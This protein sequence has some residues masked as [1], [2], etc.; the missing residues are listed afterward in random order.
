LS[1][2]GQKRDMHVIVARWPRPM[3][4]TTLRVRVCAAEGK[5]RGRM[6]EPCLER[7]AIDPVPATRVMAIS[8]LLA[9][10]AV[11][12]ILVAIRT[13]RKHHVDVLDVRITRTPADRFVAV[14]ARHVAMQAGQ[15]IPG[16]GMIKPCEVIPGGV[17]MTAVARL[18]GELPGMG[19]VGLMTT[20]AG[21]SYAQKRGLR[22]T[23]FADIRDH[24]RRDYQLGSVAIPTVKVGV[25]PVECETGA[26]VGKRGGIDSG[27]IEI[28]TKVILMAVDAMVVGERRVKAFLLPHTSAQRRVALE[29]LVIRGAAA[30]DGVATRAIS[31][32]AQLGVGCS[33]FPWGNELRGREGRGIQHEAP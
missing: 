30:P 29:T 31:H 24:V 14:F 6:V 32:A 13:T 21:G 19:I 3:A 11:V 33:Q 20:E 22:P 4:T 18:V 26:V 28:E 1:R 9:H 15:A 10:L 5:G 25:T 16:L 17:A 8:A 2:L 27:H 23:V 12:I 7:W